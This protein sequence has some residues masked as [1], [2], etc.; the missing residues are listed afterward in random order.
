[1][2]S[3]ITKFKSNMPLFEYI[4]IEMKS[5]TRDAA[6]INL[7]VTTLRSVNVGS[8]A[9]PTQKYIL[10]LEQMKFINIKAQ[11]S[12]KIFKNLKSLDGFKFYLCIP[13]LSREE[14]MAYSKFI[15]NNGGSIKTNLTNVGKDSFLIK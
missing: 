3:L 10:S 1:M 2:H 15:L 6:S 7:A 12:H 5:S 9:N 4:I 8:S 11:K 13:S 14:K